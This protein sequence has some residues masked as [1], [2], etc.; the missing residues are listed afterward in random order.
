MRNELFTLICGSTSAAEVSRP[1]VVTG[2]RPVE[3]RLGLL[4]FDNTKNDFPWH[5]FRVKKSALR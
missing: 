4:N 2:G 1:D 5:K 3:V